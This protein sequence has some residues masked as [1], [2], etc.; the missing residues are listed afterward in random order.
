VVLTAASEGLVESA[1]ELRRK[2]D[3]R[4]RVQPER[5]G[6]VEAIGQQTTGK[7]IQMGKATYKG[8]VPQD[9]PMFSSG[10]QLFSRLG[11]QRPSKEDANEHEDERE[12]EEMRAGLKMLVGRAVQNVQREARQHGKELGP[13]S[14][15]EILEM[16]EKG[17][18]PDS[19]AVRYLRKLVAKDK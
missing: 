6:L 7:R 8:L 16:V 3:A 5:A 13:I 11:S 10:P 2:A 18:L 9:D 15:A 14:P 12:E 17:E 1:T 4:L 19:D